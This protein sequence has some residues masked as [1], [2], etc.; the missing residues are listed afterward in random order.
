MKYD[1]QTI[2]YFY[3]YNAETRIS[4]ITTSITSITATVDAVAVSVNIVY[5]AICIIKDTSGTNK[6]LFIGG[7]ATNTNTLF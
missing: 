2:Q 7:L 5:P 3:N 4:H 1:N 6:T